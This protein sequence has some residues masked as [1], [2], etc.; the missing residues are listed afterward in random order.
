MQIKM[1]LNISYSV[2]VKITIEM[3]KNCW[4]KLYDTIIV[5]LD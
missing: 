1:D 2:V 5:T 4:Y 3:Y